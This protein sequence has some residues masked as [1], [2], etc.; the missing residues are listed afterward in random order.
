MALTVR[1]GLPN[2]PRSS[3]RW[4][5][6]LALAP[7]GRVRRR[8]IPVTFVTGW[9]GFPT[10][11]HILGGSHP[12]VPLLGPLGTWIPF[13]PLVLCPP[14]PPG[15]SFTFYVVCD[16]FLGPVCNEMQ[17]AILYDMV[18]C[19]GP[20]CWWDVPTRRTI[21]NG[22]PTPCMPYWRPLGTYIPIGFQYI[23]TPGHPS[24]FSELWR[25]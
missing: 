12:L 13:G 10:G 17:L 23:G 16:I 6:T 18:H 20:T 19:F 22:V 7:H 15:S 21:V 8:V 1:K 2:G 9:W 11:N 25:E 3:D 14:R 24:L 4:I 5:L